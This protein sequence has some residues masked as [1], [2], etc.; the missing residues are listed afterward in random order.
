MIT[1]DIAMNLAIDILAKR[2]LLLATRN[3]L[4]FTLHLTFEHKF[5][6]ALKKMRFLVEIVHK[7]LLISV[8]WR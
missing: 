8:L 5:R 1:I 3:Q 2:S 6:S 4:L 7:I